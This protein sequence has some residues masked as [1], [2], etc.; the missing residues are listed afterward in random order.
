MLTCT[1]CRS[2][3]KPS[4]LAATSLMTDNQN[5]LI[6]SKRF[7]DITSSYPLKLHKY[8]HTRSVRNFLFQLDKLES[9]WAHQRIYNQLDNYFDLIDES[10][11]EDNSESIM[12]Y[13]KFILPIAKTFNQFIPLHLVIRTRLVVMFSIIP[14]LLLYMFKSSLYFSIL[15][16]AIDIVLYA[17]QLYYKNQK[18]SYGP[19]Y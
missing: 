7:E 1:E 11:I 10:F 15:L 19:F 9:E 4:T 5:L 18:S 17:R 3:S 13:D 6:L 14:L 12:L 16:I 2:G 8:I